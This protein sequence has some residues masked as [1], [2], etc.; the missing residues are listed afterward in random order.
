[1][2]SLLRYVGS[3]RFQPTQSLEWDQLEK[4]LWVQSEDRG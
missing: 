4:T 1:M 3:D 2:H